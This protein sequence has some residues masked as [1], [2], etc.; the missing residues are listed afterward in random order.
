V[1]V[2]SAVDRFEAALKRERE[3]FA[4]AFD[5]RVS[6]IEAKMRESASS[7]EGRVASLRDE[8][9]AFS[10]A[11]CET[12]M[13]SNEIIK[14]TEQ[15]LVLHPDWKI[16]GVLASFNANP[17]L[18][19]VDKVRE[20]RWLLRTQSSSNISQTI[21]ELFPGSLAPKRFV[22]SPS[23]PLDGIIAHLTNVCGGN[24]NDRDVVMV[25]SSTSEY[26]TPKA[27]ADLKSDAY[28]GSKYRRKEED[29][30]HT[31]NNWVC[32][33]FKARRIVPTHYSIRSPAHPH[34]PGYGNYLKSWLVEI[35]TDGE[36]WVEI[37]R[38]EN[39]SE[40][41]AERVTRTFEVSGNQLC[42]QIRLVNIGRNHQ[43]YDCLCILAL[44]VFGSL[45]E[46]LE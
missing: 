19:L 46:S 14:H 8:V 34:G 15:L 39:N 27:I 31:R 11:R 17:Q 38:R 30:P 16:P 33:D 45:I 32:Y 37:G 36:H 18:N 24:V 43:G 41:A 5:A 26:G 28:F 10:V 40:L 23:D 20:V 13:Q 42:R 2:G 21:W 29:I 22:L 12:M 3:S 9:S 4:S 7:F 44:E 6:Q 25:T 1:A 35:S